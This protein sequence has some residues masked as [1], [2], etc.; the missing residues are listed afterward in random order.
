LER[1]FLMYDSQGKAV[2]MVGS[3]M[4]I[5][6]RRRA[7]EM[8]SMQ[9]AELA[10]IARVRTMGEIATG[11]GHELNQPLAAVANYAES[12]VQALSS[13]S[14]LDT[15]KLLQWIEK[16]AANTHRA[17]EIIRGLR[18]FSR[19][20]KPRRASTCVD[21]L[22]REVI[23][24]MKPESRRRN[25]RVRWSAAPGSRVIVD[26]VQVQ[27]VLVNL[28][29]NAFDAAAELPPERRLV[30]IAATPADG[31]VELSVS[32]LGRGI[33]PKNLDRVFDAFFSTKSG[34][35]GIGLAISRSIVEDHAGRMWL[36]ANPRHGVT[37]HF[38]LP[39]AEVSNGRVASRS[40]C[41]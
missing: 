40:S 37:F 20:S 19:K 25:M 30:T 15:A 38:T 13:T 6:N 23:E 7:E 5:S 36:T 21:D 32:D 27:Q 33:D 8:A 34:G 14:P 41:R 39:I 17:G 11:L 28:L 29:Y 31:A 3:L 26:S 12:C 4:D 9:Q 18:A 2:R 10:R 1:G 22:V 16:I 24:L 35:V